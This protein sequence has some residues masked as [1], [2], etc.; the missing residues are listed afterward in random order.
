MVTTSRAENGQEVALEAYAEQRA[1]PGAVVKWPD[2]SCLD[3]KF[4]GGRSR[5][6]DQ[7][8]RW[9][10]SG[11]SDRQADRP[12]RR[13]RETFRYGLTWSRVDRR[14]PFRGGI[15]LHRNRIRR[16]VRCRPRRGGRI[17]RCVRWTTCRLRWIT[18]CPCGEAGLPG[19]IPARSGREDAGIATRSLTPRR[20][21]S[22]G[23]SPIRRE[24]STA[25]RD[26]STGSPSVAVR[27]THILHTI[28][29]MMTR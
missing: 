17:H 23:L 10:A 18:G 13:R 11:S 21:S 29:T 1:Q 5:G 25:G 2:D 12:G 28:I 8:Q 26:Y 22:T 9:S 14:A 6:F 24:P 15:L 16:A 27:R 3:P 20:Q 4:R 7:F 19:T